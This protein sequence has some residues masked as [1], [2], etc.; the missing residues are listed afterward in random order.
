MFPTLAHHQE[1]WPKP[2]AAAG[3]QQREAKRELAQTAIPGVTSG[4][5]Q[6]CGR[7]FVISLV[8]SQ[9]Q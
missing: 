1:T 2:Y 3:V 4:G 8:L 7:H 9:Q 6:R 5:Q